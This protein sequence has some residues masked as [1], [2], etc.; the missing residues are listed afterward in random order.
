MTDFTW[1]F[2]TKLQLEFENFPADQ[3][4]KILLFASTYE[5]HGLADF[6]RYEGKLSPS[7][8]TL[9]DTDPNHAYAQLNALWH[10]HVGI[11]E[12]KVVHGKYKTSDMVLHFQWP[13]KGTHISLVDVYY[14]HKSDGTFYIPP[15]AYLT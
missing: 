5:E 15:L 3:Q 6:T 9:P 14:H 11:P 12:Y 10:Y 7:W 1:S 8:A 2:K 4:D 13:D